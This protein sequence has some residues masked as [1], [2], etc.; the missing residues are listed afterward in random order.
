MNK[1]YALLFFTLLNF[2]AYGTPINVSELV[3]YAGEVKYYDLDRNIIINRAPT[4]RT[5]LSCVSVLLDSKQI[6][7][8]RSYYKI[9]SPVA[10]DIPANVEGRTAFVENNKKLN[11]FLDYVR[12]STKDI[13]TLSAIRVIMYHIVDNPVGHELICKILDRIENKMILFKIEGTEFMYLPISDRNSMETIIIPEIIFSEYKAQ[14]Q[15]I[16]SY[17]PQQDGESWKFSKHERP[18]Y[19]G[20]VHELIHLM[21]NLENKRTGEEEKENLLYS[22][23]FGGEKLWGRGDDLYTIWGVYSIT[24]EFKNI[25]D[26]DFVSE[27]TFRIYDQIPVRMFYETFNE[28]IGNFTLERYVSKVET[29]EGESDE[30]E[31]F[32]NE[33]GEE[34]EPLALLKEILA[35]LKQ[36]KIITISV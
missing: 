31:M 30:E 33:D 16:T 20:L 14:R 7:P 13:K 21:H 17:G 11:Q 27:L 18:F 19:I 35:E 5:D 15:D 23:K 28:F 1:L 10:S 9:E 34:I 26:Y 24:R 3:T 12:F 29:E 25:V 6:Q 36:E 4:A 22:N 8:E 32:E 2:L